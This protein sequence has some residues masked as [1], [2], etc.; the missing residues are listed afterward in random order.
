MGA[1]LVATYR[2][3]DYGVVATA[4]STRPTKDDQVLV[5][6]GDITDRKT[7]ERS[8]SEGVARF[9]RIDTL[10]P[11]PAPMRVAVSTMAPITFG[12]WPMPV[13]IS[14]STTQLDEASGQISKLTGSQARS[15]KA[16]L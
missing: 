12:C 11:A 9:G 3:R 2:D 16:S 15:T 13:K 7:A 6:P 10:T 4:R 14:L 1:A 5:V 8:I